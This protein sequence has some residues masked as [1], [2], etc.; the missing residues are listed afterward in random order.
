M[1][2][3][4]PEDLKHLDRFNLGKGNPVLTSAT[5]QTQKSLWISPKAL[6]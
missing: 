1:A 5:P 4:Q 2:F 6:E 3:T